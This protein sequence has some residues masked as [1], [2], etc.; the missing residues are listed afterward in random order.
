MSREG[1]ET[2]QDSQVFFGEDGTD[3]S[4]FLTGAGAVLLP[5]AL[6][7]MQLFCMVAFAGKADVRPSDWVSVHAHS[8]LE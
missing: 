4:V 5:G 2:L 8:Q 1:E 3:F 6:R 7:V